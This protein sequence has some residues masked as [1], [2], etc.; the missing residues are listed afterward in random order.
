MMGQLV[1]KNVMKRLNELC[2]DYYTEK[3]V[4][5][6]A[7]HTHSGP[8]GI[9]I[10]ADD[11]S[12]WSSMIPLYYLFKQSKNGIIDYFPFNCSLLNDYCNHY[13]FVCSSIWCNNDKFF[14]FAIASFQ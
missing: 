1:K 9:S 14:S 12:N 5:I 2:P 3:N 13:K 6:S 11:K 4:V 8:A 7:T 10:S